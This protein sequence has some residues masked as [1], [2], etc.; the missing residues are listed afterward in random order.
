LALI[1]LSCAYYGHDV[2][3][4]YLLDTSYNNRIE[5]TTLT[6]DRVQGNFDLRF[7]L[8]ETVTSSVHWSTSRKDSVLHF[9]NGSFDFVPPADWADALE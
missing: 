2:S 7:I 8:S 5:F 3:A 9:S 6:K 1:F 4:T